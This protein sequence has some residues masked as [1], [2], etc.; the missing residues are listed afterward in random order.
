MCEPFSL[1]CERT[2]FVMP[3]NNSKRTASAPKKP[4]SSQ[5]KLIESLKQY[6]RTRGPDLLA[7]PN[8]SSVGIGHKIKNG[9]RGKQVALQFTVKSKAEPEALEALGTTRIPETITVDG[10]DVPTDVIERSYQPHFRVVTEVEKPK[11]KTRL[12]PIVPGASIGGVTVS[13]GTIG[14][15]VFDKADGTPYVLSNW[16]VLQG[17]EGQLGEEVVQPG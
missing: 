8:V 15:I 9:T 6:I 11:R 14:C 12:N 4:A 5:D 2:S 1:L 17:P 7:D 3:T 13:A 10:V 16:H